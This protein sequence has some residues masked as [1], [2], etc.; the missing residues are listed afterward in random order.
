MQ[1]F[2]F[3]KRGSLSRS[4]SVLPSYVSGRMCLREHLR[5]CWVRLKTRA[6]HS[7]RPFLPRISHTSLYFPQSLDKASPTLF[8]AFTSRV[9]AA[10]SE[11]EK[12]PISLTPV[13]WAV[14]V[15]MPIAHELFMLACLVAG[16]LQT[17]WDW[18]CSRGPASPPDRHTQ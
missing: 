14:L 6:V 7:V 13:H 18:P 8:C 4:W 16:V 2:L 10:T 5:A 12:K 11:M 1:R 17:S 3:L 15:V 9:I